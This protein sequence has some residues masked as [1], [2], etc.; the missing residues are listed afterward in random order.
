MADVIQTIMERMRGFEDRLKDDAERRRK[1]QIAWENGRDA[2]AY[3]RETGT[4]LYAI[5][6]QCGLIPTTLQ[7]FVRFYRLYPEGY[8]EMID[9]CPLMWGH[10]QAVLY[11]RNP[12]ERAWY[13]Q[14]AA[15][16]GWST[17]ETRLRV[18]RHFYEST[19]EVSS[20]AP[21][22]PGSVVISQTNQNLYTYAARVLKVIDADTLTVEVDVGFSMRY[23]TKIRLR[24]INAAEKGTRLGDAAKA[25]VEGE[26]GLG[27]TMEDPGEKSEVKGEESR[28][29]Q[30]PLGSSMIDDRS[31]MILVKTYKSGKYGRFI[32]DVWYLNGENDPEKI[33]RDGH[34]LNQILLDRGYA[35]RA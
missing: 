30:E 15:Q 25:F 7:R 6:D 5:A 20:G 33:L 26:L 19:Q 12:Q 31:A 16:N 17:Q 32:A 21:G 9:G 34:W 28:E 29:A 24:G 1:L 35:Q 4:G 22:N 11:V 13:L 2:Y 14:Q 10:Y 23:E 27:K 3:K 8:Q 18:R